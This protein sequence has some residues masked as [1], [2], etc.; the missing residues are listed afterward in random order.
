MALVLPLAAAVALLGM[1][2]F[3]GRERAAVS[4]VAGVS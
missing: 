4:S 1:S 3:A 2:L